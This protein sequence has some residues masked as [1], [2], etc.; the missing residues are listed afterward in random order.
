VVWAL[1]EKTGKEIWHTRLAAGAQLSQQQGGNGPRSTPT[2]DGDYLYVEGASGDLACLNVSD[3][4]IRWKK[5][6]VSDFGGR[7]PPWGYSESPLV[8]GEKVIAT[9][10]GNDSTLVALNKSNG[11]VIWKS[12]VPSANAVSYASSIIADVDGQREYIQFLAKGVV[13]VSAKDG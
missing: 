5:S 11:E 12:Q 10:G 1:N 8:D 4:K 9:P 2:V 6:L 3:G 7:I 13:G